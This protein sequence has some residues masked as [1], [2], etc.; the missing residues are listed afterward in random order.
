MK[1][2]CLV[3]GYLCVAMGFALI[4]MLGYG[5]LDPIGVAPDAPPGSIGGVLLGLLPS[6]L[7]AGTVFGIGLYLVRRARRP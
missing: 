3:A 6:V 7:L 2:M 4:V 1:R 5:V